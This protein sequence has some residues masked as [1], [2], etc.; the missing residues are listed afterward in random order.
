MIVSEEVPDFV[1]ANP[2]IVRVE[3][4]SQLLFVVFQVESRLQ[5]YTAVVESVRIRD[6]LD[7][8][9]LPN[10]VFGDVIKYR[11]TIALFECLGFTN[12]ESV[13]LDEHRMVRCHRD[14]FVRVRFDG[15]QWAVIPTFGSRFDRLERE[16]P[17]GCHAQDGHVVNLFSGD[18]RLEELR[19]RQQ[20]GAGL[21][22]DKH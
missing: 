11:Q 15:V 5:I 9:K 2:A 6:H 19:Q 21:G 10:G 7:Q 18:V 1:V 16:C 3:S 4:A 17:V 20:F 14:S 22:L 8:V 13:R 12:A